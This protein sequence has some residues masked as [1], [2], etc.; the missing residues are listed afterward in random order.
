MSKK[1]WYLTYTNCAGASG[2]GYVCSEDL[3]YVPSGGGCG[4][5]YF[6]SSDLGFNAGNASELAGTVQQVSC[7]FCPGCCTDP[8][9][10]TYDCINGACTKKDVYKTPGLYANL[11]ICEEACGTGCGGKCISNADWAQIEGLSGQLMN[12]NCS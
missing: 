12:R 10:V 8:V 1:C 6:V 5:G 2:V 4:G 11:S 3:I 9:A 7:S